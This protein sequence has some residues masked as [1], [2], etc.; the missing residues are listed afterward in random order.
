MKAEFKSRYKMVVKEDKRIVKTLD[1]LENMT[2]AHIKLANNGNNTLQ[3]TVDAFVPTRIQIAKLS[4]S[5]ICNNLISNFL[6]RTYNGSVT[7]TFKA[8]SSEDFQDNS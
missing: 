8:P 4:F 5:R 6:K 7:V 3:V 1:V 2:R